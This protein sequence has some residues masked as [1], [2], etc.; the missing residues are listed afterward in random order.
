LPAEPSH[1]SRGWLVDGAGA[2]DRSDVALEP[3]PGY[4]TYF[5]DL[6]KKKAP[7][8][9]LSLEFFRGLKIGDGGGGGN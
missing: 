7:L 4:E 1:A 3:T 8:R 5:I 6:D 9:A 2:Q